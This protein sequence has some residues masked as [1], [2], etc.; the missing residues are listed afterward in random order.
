MPDA[1]RDLLEQAPLSF[2][3]TVQHMGAATMTTLAIDE[4]TAVV[5]VDHVLHAPETLQNLEGQQVTIQLLASEPTPSTG[6]AYAFFVQG[7]AFGETLAVQ[8]IGRL[9]V[10][11]VEPHATAALTAG[12]TAGA[13]DSY[14]ADIQRDRLRNHMQQADAVVVGRVIGVEKIGPLVQREHDPDWW[15]AT[16]QV[17]HVERGDVAGETLQFAY[18][19]SLDVKWHDIPKPKAS[20]GGLWILHATQGALRDVAAYE[21]KDPKD[22][23]PTQNLELIR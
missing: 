7:L 12:S 3:G 2:V 22:F 16:I 23:Q 13:F 5:H 1:I 6:E 10:E 4:H 14:T 20:Q 18:P 11:D 9:P 21:L 17:M 15:R 19:N 8:E